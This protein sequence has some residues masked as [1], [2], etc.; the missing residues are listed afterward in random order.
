MY[1]LILNRGA[2]K[3]YL[4]SAIAIEIFII[5]PNTVYSILL[6]SLHQVTNGYLCAESALWS[7]GRTTPHTHRIGAP[8]PHDPPR[9]PSGLASWYRLVTGVRSAPSG[10][11]PSVA[12][13]RTIHAYPGT[14]RVCW[15]C[16]KYSSARRGRIVCQSFPYYWILT[17]VADV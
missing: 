15:D 11:T 8:C 17:R 3:A 4:L 16:I 10:I 1:I 9:L 12:V 2:P 6:Q 13:P 5:N 14:T 7:Q